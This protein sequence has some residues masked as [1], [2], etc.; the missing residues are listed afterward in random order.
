ME[1][2]GRQV[3]EVDIVLSPNVLLDD[4]HDRAVERFAASRIGKRYLTRTGM[5][6]EA[7]AAANMVGTA[8]EVAERLHAFTEAGMT[9]CQPA[10]IGVET[11]EAYLDQFHSFCG[12]SHSLLRAGLKVFK[13]E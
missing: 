7:G 2:V 1:A 12:W 4:S 9:H 3:S 10:H 11:F 8:E 13:E 6:P 5:T